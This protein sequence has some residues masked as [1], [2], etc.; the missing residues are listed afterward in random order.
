MYTLVY[1][2]RLPM[3]TN[4]ATVFLDLGLNRK[5]S[6]H[7]QGFLSQRKYSIGRTFFS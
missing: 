2:T 1:F 3:F 4:K 6:T 5:I 7:C